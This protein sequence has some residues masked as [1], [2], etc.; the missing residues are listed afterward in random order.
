MYLFKGH[1]NYTE[2]F[3]RILGS[4]VILSFPLVQCFNLLYIFYV[5]IK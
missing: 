4:W 2:L 1:N 3:P 5:E